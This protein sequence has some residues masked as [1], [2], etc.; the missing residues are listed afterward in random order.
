ML[1]TVTAF[2]LLSMVLVFAIAFWLAVNDVHPAAIF[3]QAMLA[4][5][6][7]ALLLLIRKKMGE[8]GLR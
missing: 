6:V 5:P 2:Y 7:A 4:W 1:K 8:L 3:V